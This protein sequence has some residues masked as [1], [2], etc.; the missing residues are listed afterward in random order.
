MIQG[1]ILHRRSVCCPACRS[2]RW[3]AYRRLPA[4]EGRVVNR[5]ACTRCGAGF[6]FTE[7]RVGRPLPAST[8]A[9]ATA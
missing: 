9:A 5:C 3:S 8:P 7:D 6:E 2:E 4:D 1:H